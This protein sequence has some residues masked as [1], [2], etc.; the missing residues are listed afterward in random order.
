MLRIKNKKNLKEIISQLKEGKVLLA[1]SD[2]VLGLFAICSAETKAKIDQVKKRSSNKP[3]LLVT[4]SLKQVEEFAIVPKAVKKLLH[5]FWPGPLTCIFK[6]Q[7]TLPDYMCS[8]TRTVAIRIP[9]QEEMQYILNEVGSLFST[10]ANISKEPIPESFK[11]ISPELLEQVEIVSVNKTM[12]YPQIPS[13]IIDCTSEN[14]RVIREGL[15]SFEKL[16]EDF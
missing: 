4:S 1:P 16:I 5:K 10:S 8:K 14:I 3:Y 7:D 13:T 11:A 2:T 9:D 15:I 12:T 6:A